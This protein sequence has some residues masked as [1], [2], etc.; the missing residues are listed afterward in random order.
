MEI[1]ASMANYLDMLRRERC[2]SENTLRVYKSELAQLV[3]WLCDKHMVFYVAHLEALLPKDISPFWTGCEPPL[4]PAGQRLR[5]SI[6]S[7]WLQ[8]MYR[9]GIM[10]SKGLWFFDAVRRNHA[11]KPTAE[12]KITPKNNMT[13]REECLWTLLCAGLR[14]A[15]IAAISPGDFTINFQRLIVK[16]KG[17]KQRIAVFDN[18]EADI[19]CHYI[20]PRRSDCMVFGQDR[21]LC[22]SSISSLRNE[23]K[24]LSIEGAAPHDYRR[25]FASDCYKNQIDA[26]VI[27]SALGHSSASTTGI[28]IS[29]SA[30]QESLMRDYKKAHPRA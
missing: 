27:Q 17:G 3:K 11:A 30:K 16:G 20:Y 9:R 19:L 14:I 7:G 15:E 5:R 22:G 1:R 6:T 21:L 10:K 23:I 4:T 24:A 26:K 8:F 13:A 2:L 29:K 25:A 28:Y 12:I 18:K